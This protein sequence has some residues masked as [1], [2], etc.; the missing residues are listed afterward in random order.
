MTTRPAQAKQS[1]VLLCVKSSLVTNSNEM[2][3]N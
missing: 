3:G 1:F 2:E